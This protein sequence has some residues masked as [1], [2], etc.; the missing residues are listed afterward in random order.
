MQVLILL[1]KIKSSQFIKLLSVRR[2]I[3]RALK[4]NIWAK[5]MEDSKMAQAYRDFK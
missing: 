5:V 2:Y 1:V 3:K 4:Y